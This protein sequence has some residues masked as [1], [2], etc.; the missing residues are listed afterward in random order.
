MNLTAI[1][2]RRPFTRPGDARRE[3]RAEAD[4][5]GELTQSEQSHVGHN[6]HILWF[7]YP[8]NINAFYA[9]VSFAVSGI[10]LSFFLTVLGA[11]IVRRRG[12][13]PSGSFK[14]GK[15]GTP[16]T[17]GA[18]VYL[19]LMLVNICWPS[20]ITSGRALF[21]Y[22]WVTLLVVLIIVVLGA[23]Y[24]GFARP[25]RK[26]SEQHR[27]ELAARRNHGPGASPRGRGCYSTVIKGRGRGSRSPRRCAQL[28]PRSL[29]RA[30]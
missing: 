27:G 29:S 1:V 6:V 10:Y 7:D 20:A 16:V 14:L 28:R 19:F 18:M 22:G 25:D 11:F 24:E 17:I 15:W 26:V 21:N 8:A 4:P 12:W 23:L 9:L 5:V 30:G 3:Q 13:E 2:T